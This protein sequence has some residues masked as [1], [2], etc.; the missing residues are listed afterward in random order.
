MK[1]DMDMKKEKTDLG[2]LLEEADTEEKVREL[3][4]SS[5]GTMETLALVLVTLKLVAFMVAR[6]DREIKELTQRNNE[7]VKK[8]KEVKRGS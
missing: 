8:L 5:G 4:Q 2:K 3:L 6:H 7:L 1:K